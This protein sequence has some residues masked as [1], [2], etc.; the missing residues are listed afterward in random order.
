M[1]SIGMLYLRLECGRSVLPN[2]LE[3]TITSEC[4]LQQERRAVASV[5][6]DTWSHDLERSPQSAE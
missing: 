5:V 4:H 1:M 6:S 3:W 2:R